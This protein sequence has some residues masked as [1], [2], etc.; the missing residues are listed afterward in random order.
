[1]FNHRPHIT[2]SNGLV[3][4]YII[5]SLLEHRPSGWDDSRSTDSLRPN[6]TM[7]WGRHTTCALDLVYMLK[8]IMKLPSQQW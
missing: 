2:W 8:N 1:M 7:S 3:V 6:V 4:Y 5:K